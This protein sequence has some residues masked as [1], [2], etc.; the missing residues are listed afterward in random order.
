[1]QLSSDARVYGEPSWKPGEAVGEVFGVGEDCRHVVAEAGVE[2]F[3]VRSLPLLL[4]AFGDLTELPAIGFRA[5][6][7]LLPDLFMRVSAGK[8]GEAVGLDP[9]AGKVKDVVVGA[10]DCGAAA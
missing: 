7:V 1:L 4:Q 2:V 3:V 10:A 9:F 5:A 6:G 8:D